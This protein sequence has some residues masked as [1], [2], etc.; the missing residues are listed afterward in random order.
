MKP[1]E[2]FA[3]IVWHR[4]D[5]R[6][7]HQSILCTGLTAAQALEG[8]AKY[9]ERPAQFRSFTDKNRVQLHGPDGLM[10]DLPAVAEVMA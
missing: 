9:L 7:V 8:F 10:C 2:Q 3:V 6:G 4:D 1:I 5:V